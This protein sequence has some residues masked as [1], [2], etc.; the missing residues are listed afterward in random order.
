MINFI[1]G[2]IVA[3][4]ATC[5]ILF[6]CWMKNKRADAQNKEFD[7]YLFTDK[8]YKTSKA[9]PTEIYYN[10]KKASIVVTH[11]TVNSEK[12]TIVREVYINDN[13]CASVFRLTDGYDIYYFSIVY[14]PYDEEEIWSI[15]KEFHK[16]HSKSKEQTTQC[17]NKISVL[18][19]EQ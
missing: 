8:W 3:V 17:C 11:N 18:K 1:C 19:E 6:V 2:I 16:Y 4:A 5:I 14:I 15:M 10:N 7:K 13:K 9:E 12:T